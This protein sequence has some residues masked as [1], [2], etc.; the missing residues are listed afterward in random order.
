MLGYMVINLGEALAISGCACTWTLPSMM[1]WSKET[2]QK[3]SPVKDA[4]HK[5][6]VSIMLPAAA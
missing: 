3:K 6:I 2:G 1:D 5:C 4:S